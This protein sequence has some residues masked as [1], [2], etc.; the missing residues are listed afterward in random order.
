MTHQLL[1]RGLAP[2]PTAPRPDGQGQ[3]L[4]V[5]VPGRDR[6]GDAEAGGGWRR[7]QAPI[8]AVAVTETQRRAE[9]QLARRWRT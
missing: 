9:R 8:A 7:R 6:G 3:R 1:T 2:I 5:R 4:V